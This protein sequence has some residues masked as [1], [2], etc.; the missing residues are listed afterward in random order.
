MVPSPL[1]RALVTGAGGFV[2]TALVRALAAR[3]DEVRALVRRRA[4]ELERTDG[5]DVVLGDVTSG[6][7]LRAAVRGCDV[8]FHL[9]GVRRATDPAE[10][11]RVNAG[12]TRLA[13][14]ACLAE[15]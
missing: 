14:D 10:F 12:S 8:V 9:A 1:V 7:S 5:V 6:A 15:A 4:P 3:G 13:L 2:G 11:L